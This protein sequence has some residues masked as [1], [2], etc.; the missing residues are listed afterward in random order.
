MLSLV[1]GM[2]M[3]MPWK[4]GQMIVRCK[5][6]DYLVRCEVASD[7]LRFR[8]N[9][10]E[11]TRMRPMVMRSLTSVTE[12]IIPQTFGVGLRCDDTRL[13]VALPTAGRRTGSVLACER[14][15]S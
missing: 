11:Q 12:S 6:L 2:R 8:Q 5:L 9:L 14:M 7:K 3:E 10:T 15:N 13:R 1:S 4:K